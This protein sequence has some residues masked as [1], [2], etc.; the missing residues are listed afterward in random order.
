MW[1]F[2]LLTGHSGIVTLIEEAAAKDYNDVLFRLPR[3]QPKEAALDYTT[4]G[5][6]RDPREEERRQDP[7]PGDGRDEAA[8]APMAANDN[9]RERIA[10]AIRYAVNGWRHEA[11]VDAFEAARVEVL[12]AWDELRERARDE[13][14]VVA[15]SPAFRQTLDRHGA[16]MKQ[17]KMFRSKPQVFERLLAERAG[18]GDGEIEELLQQ[19]ARASKY[20][21]SVRT[22]TSQVAR[23]DA[24]PEEA[25]H[26]HACLCGENR[27]G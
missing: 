17:A 25:G 9:F 27:S 21:R 18:I 2:H 16:L 1:S 26:D 22:K 12:T 6:W 20:L 15:L 11:A 13:G 5:E 8:E 3:S 4:D 10:Q 7:R 19:H 14:E 24:R 23:Q